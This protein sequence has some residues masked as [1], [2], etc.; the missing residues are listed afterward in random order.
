M[1]LVVQIRSLGPERS[2][3]VYAARIGALNGKGWG[4][5]LSML[6]SVDVTATEE[7]HIKTI[8]STIIITYSTFNLA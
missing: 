5:L 8:V 6:N 1:N 7:I 2:V 3:G 4:W